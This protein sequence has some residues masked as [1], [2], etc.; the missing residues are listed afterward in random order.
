V[1]SL[2]FEVYKVYKVIHRLSPHFKDLLTTGGKV[3][4]TWELPNPMGWAGATGGVGVYICNG[5]TK[6]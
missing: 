1:L 3:V 2:G 5:H 6:F 4:D